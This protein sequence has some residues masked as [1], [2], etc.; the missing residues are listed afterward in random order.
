[1]KVWAASMGACIGVCFS[2]CASQEN[3]H[4][5]YTPNDM[6][7]RVAPLTA[8]TWTATAI[9]NTRPLSTDPNSRAAQLN[10]IEKQSGCKVTDSDYSGQ[11]RQLDAQVDC[12]S[13]LRH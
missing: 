10:A 8:S 4:A 13:R 1:M 12:G 6:L 2:A 7:Y 11:G 9:D 3:Q 5:P